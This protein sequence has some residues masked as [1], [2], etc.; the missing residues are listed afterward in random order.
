MNTPNFEMSNGTANK[1]IDT[2]YRK[3]TTGERF[4]TVLIDRE[5]PD[6]ETFD[7][8]FKFLAEVD[9]DR[10]KHEYTYINNELKLWKKN[11]I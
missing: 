7:I 5:N 4:Y 9:I 2:L 11:D 3:I 6:P 1:E 8:D 10:F